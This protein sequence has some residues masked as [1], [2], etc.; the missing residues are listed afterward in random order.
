MEFSLMP[1]TKEE[2]NLCIRRLERFGLALTREALETLQM[3]RA[4]ALRAAG[5]VEMGSGIL[6]Q[7]VDAFCDSPDLTQENLTEELLALQEIFYHW[8][9]EAGDCAPD[10]ELLTFLRRAYDEKGRGGAEGLAGFTLREMKEAMP[11]V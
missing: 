4:A 6:P 3:G 2:T 8:K 10:H 7:L 1:Y 11:R 9:S 5:R